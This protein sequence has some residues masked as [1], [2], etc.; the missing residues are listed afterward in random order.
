MCVFMTLDWMI[1]LKCDIENTS[2]ITVD[3]LN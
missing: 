2:K 1:I 3:N